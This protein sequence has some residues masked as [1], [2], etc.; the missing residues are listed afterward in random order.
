MGI[1][2]GN[3]HVRGLSGLKC[4]TSVVAVTIYLQLLF[5]D[6]LM[7]RLVILRTKGCFTDIFRAD[8]IVRRPFI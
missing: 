1:Y 5:H 8:N 7:N 3:Q 6:R 4:R 2:C